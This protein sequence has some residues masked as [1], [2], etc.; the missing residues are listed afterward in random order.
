MNLK[1][2]ARASLFAVLG[3]G[4]IAAQASTL[5]SPQASSDIQ[6]MQ[7]H[8]GDRLDIKKVVSVTQ[9]DANTCGVVNTRMEYRDS[10]GQL[11]GLD[12]RSYATGG[13]YDN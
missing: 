5:A 6:V 12:Y 13:C 7:Y 10:Q 3:L 9:E 1:T 2:L 4:A 11:H 8:Y